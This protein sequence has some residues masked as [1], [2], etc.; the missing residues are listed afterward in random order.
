MHHRELA[1]CRV[2]SHYV[3][4]S[5][6]KLYTIVTNCFTCYFKNSLVWYAIFNVQLGKENVK[7]AADNLS[8]FW[9]GQLIHQTLIW[10]VYFILSDIPDLLE[11][12]LP[13]E[14]AWLLWGCTDHGSHS[15]KSESQGK[16]QPVILESRIS[17]WSSGGFVFKK[18]RLPRMA[19]YQTPNLIQ[20]QKPVY[21]KN[22][23]S[24]FFRLSTFR[25]YLSMN[26][27][28]RKESTGHRQRKI[29][30]SSESKVLRQTGQ[31]T[32]QKEVSMFY[33]QTYN[34]VISFVTVSC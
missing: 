14:D 19:D 9:L 1:T 6:L 3:Y 15:G 31:V 30:D 7:Y 34:P 5:S 27:R 20:R 8:S 2:L 23:I 10:Q 11:L 17:M 12:W 22:L 18:R 24:H 29:P 28:A 16:E 21:V 25:Q 13:R 32:V 4:R 26:T 33:P